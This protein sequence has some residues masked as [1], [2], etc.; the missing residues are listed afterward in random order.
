M[1]ALTSYALMLMA[2][3]EMLNCQS[4]SISQEMMA[5]GYEA[6]GG[7]YYKFYMTTK[8]GQFAASEKCHE[9]GARLAMMKSQEDQEAWLHYHGKL[10]TVYNG[11]VVSLLLLKNVLF[12]FC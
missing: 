7:K 1:S 9:F 8:M 4:C 3:I 6:R 2:F 12:L 11:N 5:E 10:Y